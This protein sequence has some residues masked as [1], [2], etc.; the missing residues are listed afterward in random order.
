[1]ADISQPIVPMRECVHV[2]FDVKNLE[3]AIDFFSS[4]FGWGPWER[5]EVER[6]GFL[7]GKPI[8]Y[9]AIRAWLKLGPV[10]FEAGET[11]GESF[12][13]E[14][15]ASH[16]GGLHHLAFEVDDVE[17]AV[18]KLDKIGIPI[19]QSGIGEDG[20][21]MFVYMDTQKFSTG[22]IVVELIRRGL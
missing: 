10:T 21:Y 4:V 20:K 2:G 6:K 16:G 12:H 3:K 5:W 7:R 9:K 22:N 18:A 17:E 19:L 14:F 1:M 8:T 13:T 11:H 15:V